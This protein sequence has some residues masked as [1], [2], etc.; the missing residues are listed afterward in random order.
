MKRILPILLLISLF[1]SAVS[2]TVTVIDPGAAS[3]TGSADGKPGAS[4]AP[5]TKTATLSSDADP[6]EES[7]SASSPIPSPSGS[8]EGL[9][10]DEIRDFSGLQPSE[11]YQAAV[12]YYTNA[13]YRDGDV[14]RFFGVYGEQPLGGNFTVS[15]VGGC[16]SVALEIDFGENLPENN[17]GITVT[18]RIVV[19]EDDRGEYPVW[20]ALR[21]EIA[22]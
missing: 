13:L 22:A 10:E 4:P 9:D 14:V 19:L 7:A 16:C 3:T 2:C 17:T 5:V 15:D 1:F 6:S 8:E 20:R 18:A 11:Q 21:W 12:D